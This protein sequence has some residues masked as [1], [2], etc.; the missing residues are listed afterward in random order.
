[1]GQARWEVRQRE[2][3]LW[4]LQGFIGFM[5]TQYFLEILSYSYVLI[6]NRNVYANCT[7]TNFVS[8]HLVFKFQ[9]RYAIHTG[10]PRGKRNITNPAY[11]AGLIDNQVS[12]QYK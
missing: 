12:L 4:V 11:N 6:E 8:L 7:H 10:S 2:E 3:S 5:A 9:R 1:M